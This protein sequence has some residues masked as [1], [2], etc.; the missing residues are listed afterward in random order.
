MNMQSTHSSGFIARHRKLIVAG[1]VLAAITTTVVMLGSKTALP[2][3]TASD[4]LVMPYTLSGHYSNNFQLTGTV[5]ARTET[6][7]GFRVSG[8]IIGKLVD[9]GQH[10]TKGQALMKI[11]AVDLELAQRAADQAVDAAKA[12]NVRALADESRLKELLKIQAVSQQDYERAKSTAEAS[13]AQLMA[14][15]ANAKH[16]TNEVDYSVLQAD[17]DGVIMEVPADVGQVV[18]AG[19][20]VIRLAQDGAREAVVNL[21][22]SALDKAKD[23]K[24]ASL[25]GDTGTKFPVELRELSASADPMTRT[26]QARYTLNGAGHDAPLG[27]TVTVV[28]ESQSAEDQGNFQV[29]IGALY[30]VGQGP[31]V[32]VISQENSTVNLHPIKVV[33]LSDE[34]AVIKGDIK[35][36]D[37]IVALGAHLL[38]PGEKVRVN[39]QEEASK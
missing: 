9:Q 27:S 5:H 11:D 14:A 10:V 38:N 29:P 32:W 35:P 18:S 2:T 31:N 30:D 33:Q 28:Y 15:Q 19:Q 23:A 20:T 17:A 6:N 36:G 26:Y 12:E 37:R 22:E 25:Y 24:D 1:A 13:T 39:A 7:L 4:S 8:K 34:T 16:A 3:A 21:P